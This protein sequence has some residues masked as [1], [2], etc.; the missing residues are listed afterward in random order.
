MRKNIGEKLNVKLAH[1]VKKIGQN[2]NKQIKK[3]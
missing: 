1:K 3:N 2:W